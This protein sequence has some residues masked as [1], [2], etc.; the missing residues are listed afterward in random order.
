VLL[1]IV[2]AT[3]TVAPRIV[4]AA[5]GELPG[6]EAGEAKRLNAEAQELFASGSYVEAARAYA[7]ILEV[8]G[9]NKINREERDNTLLIALEV[10]REAFRNQRDPAN[11]TITR[12]A[13]QHLCSADKLYAK[14]LAEYQDVYGSA[15]E[16]SKAARESK[17]DLDTLLSG[18]AEELDSPPCGPLEVAP[19]V[20]EAPKDDFD[21]ILGNGVDPPRGPSGVGLIVGGSVTMAAGVGAT[22]MIIIGASQRRRAK[23]AESNEDESSS[24]EVRKRNDDNLRRANGLIIAGSVVTAVLLAGG[25]TMLGIGIKRRLRYLAFS[26]TIDRGYVGLSLQGRF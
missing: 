19:P 10:Y 23:R 12:E 22:S 18:V 15:A 3:S 26:P 5:P 7:R 20:V 8:L 9:E 6:E 13:A 24:D 17:A 4:H 2:L 25:A 11:A 21:D 16:P 1:G 14:Y